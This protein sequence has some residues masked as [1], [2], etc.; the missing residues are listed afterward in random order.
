MLTFRYMINKNMKNKNYYTVKELAD[1]LGISRVAVFNKIKKGQIK[2]EK[3]GR[4]YI[5][6]KK[7]IDNIIS[8][9][10]SDKDKNEI[11]KGVAKVIKEYGETLKM[12]GNE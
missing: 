3:M 12:L 4:N 8:K 1:I 6:Y 5:I 11:K 10:L 2:A 7:D 9:E